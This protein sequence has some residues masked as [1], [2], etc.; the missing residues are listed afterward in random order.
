MS[1]ND[2]D[3]FFV[4]NMTKSRLGLCYEKGWRSLDETAMSINVD[5]VDEGSFII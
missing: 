1:S 3:H 4:E 2:N 5:F